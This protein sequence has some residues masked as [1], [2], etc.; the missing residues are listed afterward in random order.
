MTE[1]HYIKLMENMIKQSCTRVSTTIV[2]H[3]EIAKILTPRCTG[4]RGVSRVY[5]AD[6]NIESLF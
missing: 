4:H 1:K 5:P 3:K 2:E 6:K